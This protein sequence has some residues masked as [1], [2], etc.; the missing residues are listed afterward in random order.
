M[1]PVKRTAFLAALIAAGSM[2]AARADDNNLAGAEIG[3]SH[4]S[5]F[6]ASPADVPSTPDSSTTLS[7]YLGRYW[8]TEDLRSALVL[9]GEA[10]L[11]RQNTF[12]TLNSTDFGASVGYYHA[13]STHNVMTV[14]AAELV[15]RFSDQSFDSITRSLQVT[16]RHKLSETVS[17][18][19]SAGVER[20]NVST[21]D[22]GYD[23]RTLVAS[24]TWR[25]SRPTLLSVSASR[26]ARTYD[27]APGAARA[28]R[29][30]GIGWVQQL[31]GAAY[32][33]AAVSGQRNETLAGVKYDSTVYSVGVGVS[34]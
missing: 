7:G 24:G 17:L 30:L 5:N 12:T 10:A 25:P 18:R 31:G 21:S 14:S 11:V 32:L 28:G 3:Y 19:G 26:S 4:D 20:S 13:F 34:M 22:F 1:T 8:P 2:H 29:Q 33:R 27:G 23:G 16:L 6:L 15:R 9:R